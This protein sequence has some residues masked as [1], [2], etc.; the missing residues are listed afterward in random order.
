MT[1]VM[2]DVHGYYDKYLSFVE[3]ARFHDEDTLYV[4]G[5]TINRGFDAIKMLRD[6]MKRKNVITLKGNHERTMAAIFEKIYNNPS[7]AVDIIKEEMHRRDIGQEKTLKDFAKLSTAQMSEIIAFIEQMPLY[8]KRKVGGKD[9]ILVHAGLQ[10][11]KDIPI[12]YYDKRPLLSG[13]HDFTIKHYP[14]TTI[15]VGHKPTR[16]IKGATPDRIFHS[17][18]TIGIDCGLGFG[19][20]LGVLC[21]ETGEE[22]Y[23]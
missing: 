4:I 6:V 18:D 12:E 2:S 9:Y 21:L 7:N 16:F 5:D 8:L 13:Q 19:G 20:Q 15:I 17:V 22:L 10:D 11:F 14:N 3:S 1:Y 23:F